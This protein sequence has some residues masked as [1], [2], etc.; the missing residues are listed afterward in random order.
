VIKDTDGRYQLMNTAAKEQLDID[1]ERD[2]VGLTDHDLFPEAVAEQFRA[3][4][5]EVIDAGEPIE[6]E[7]EVPMADDRSIYHTRK[8]PLV[9]ADGTVEGVCA[10][11]R[12]ITERKDSQRD[13]REQKRQLQGVLDSVD[14]SI[15]IRDL[16]SRFELVNQNVRAMFGLAGDADVVDEH[17][18]D[19]FS[20]EIASQFV[21]ND[22]EVIETGAP[23]E[24]Q[25]EMA[26]ERGT[27]TYLTRI[28]PLFDDGELLATCGV[29]TDITAQKERERR[30]E[31][32]NERLDQF[33]STLR[34]ELRNPLNVPDGYLDVARE[35]GSPEAF[36][37]CQTAVDQ[38]Q[39][40]LEQTLSV[41]KRGEATLDE[42][43]LELGAMCEACWRG[44]PETGA[45]VEFTTTREVVADE[46][47]MT[48]LLGNLFRNAVEHGGPAVV[49]R[50]GDLET[51]FYVEDDGPGIPGDIREAVFEEGYSTSEAG[52]GLG[53]A[54]VEA[55]ATAH[56]W[57]VRITD[58]PM[59][60]ARFEIT[61]VEFA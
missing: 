13:L 9:D 37:S 27:G 21:S 58:G 40:L 2:V 49:V 8:R 25:E 7:E 31:R 20:E 18:S 53:L 11:S 19:L 60:G 1:P 41:L 23:I 50:V 36:E 26:T 39:Q 30:L 57:N 43:P 52:T 61:D 38:M 3:E 12:D 15:W 22:R 55:V 54:V 28:T 5:Q 56:G 16:D 51:G 47:R 44:M 59:G 14:A 33:A 10:I 17:P 4:D 42:T 45:T 24:R 29:A 35:T 48:Q 6:R 46:D 32:H 34:H